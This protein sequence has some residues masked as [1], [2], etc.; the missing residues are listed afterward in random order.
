MGYCVTQVLKCPLRFSEVVHMH[1]RTDCLK[2]QPSK[3][4]EN[5]VC[6]AYTATE[7]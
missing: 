6:I 4:I 1:A 2:R 7:V 3:C 5:A